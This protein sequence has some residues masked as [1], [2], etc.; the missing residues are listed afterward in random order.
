MNPIDPSQ[1]EL[2]HAA[3]SELDVDWDTLALRAGIKPRALK[4]YRLPASSTG[5][6]AMPDLARAAIADLLRTATR[7]SGPTQ[8]EYLRSAMSKLKLTWSQLAEAAGIKPLTFKNY[9]R[10]DSALAHRT[11]PP[12][13]KAA[14]ER[15]LRDHTAK[16]R[17][18]IA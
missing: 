11:L 8:Q 18:N 4:S 2:L 1:Q 10:S 6:R 9:L 7:E 3:K 13:A 17:N 15:L 12:L 5:S 16:Q 14:V